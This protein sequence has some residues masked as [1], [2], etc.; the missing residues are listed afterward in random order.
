MKHSIREQIEAEA[1]K[2]HAAGRWAGRKSA[3]A[4]GQKLNVTS[5]ITVLRIAEAVIAKTTEGAS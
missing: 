1:L 3:V 2:L 4:V 5:T